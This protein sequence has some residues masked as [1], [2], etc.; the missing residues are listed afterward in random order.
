MKKICTA[1]LATALTVVLM[2][3]GCNRGSATPSADGAS[4]SNDGNAVLT[5]SASD[6]YI[7]IL[8]L[9]NI[10]YFNAHKYEW[11]KVGDLMGVKASVMGPADMDLPATVTAIDQAIAQHPKGI[12]IWGVDP[13][14]DESINKAV[15]AGIPVVAI[16]GDQPGSNRLTYIGSYGEDLGYLGGK[17]LA[18][19]LGGNGKVS[20]LTVPG[21]AQWD[22][23][24][25]G[26]RKAFAEYPGIEVVAVGDT[27]ADTVTAVQ[28]AKDIMVRFPDLNGFVGCDSTAAIGAATAVEET[29]NVGKVKIIGMDRN[30]DIMEK[31]RDGIITG[32]IAQNDASIMYWAMLTL[33]SAQSEYQP[34]LTSNNQAAGASTIPSVIYLP[35]SYVDQSNLEY[36]LEANKIYADAK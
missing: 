15:D 34:T 24:E 17:K 9:S 1:V 18:E 26:Y 29:G 27:K 21:Y 14:L 13:S 32:T 31:I 25:A 16:V 11:N 7:F 4:G 36:Y 23:R 19:E 33:I 30:S 28:A 22:E 5:T 6:G 12:C 10:E 8:A 35:P 20:I 2:L 3:A